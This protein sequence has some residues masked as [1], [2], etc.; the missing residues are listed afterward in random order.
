MSTLLQCLIRQ[1]DPAVI[2]DSEAFAI[3]SSGRRIWNIINQ[4]AKNLRLRIISNTV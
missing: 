4:I 1:I 3:M 2:C